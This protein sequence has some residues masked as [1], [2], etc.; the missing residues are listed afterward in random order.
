MAVA[1]AVRPIAQP[2]DPARPLGLPNYQLVRDAMRSD[3]ARS[4]L[5]G[6][7]R[8]KIGELC[9]RYGLSPAPI[10]EALGQLEAEGWIVILPN[11]GASVRIIDETFLRD[12]NEIR[13]ALESFN[14]GLCAAACTEGDLARLD[15]IE[16]EYESR[17]GSNDVAGLIQAN[18]RLHA[19]MNAIRANPESLAIIRRQGMFFNT[20][21]A[22]WGYGPG[23]PDE[24][25]AEHRALLEAFRRND[26]AAAERISREHIGKAMEDLLTRWR[27]GQPASQC[28]A[29]SSE[30][31]MR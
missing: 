13:V 21:R 11:R 27:A 18:G 29:P 30:Q 3:I 10:R 17:L 15:A 19:A 22:E 25:A 26:G 20:M 24:I 12:M 9:Q 16:T 5:Q 31:A 4:V 1:E 7:A 6:G 23:R 2:A 14:A 8:L 28:A